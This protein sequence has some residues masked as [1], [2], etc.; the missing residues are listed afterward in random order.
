MSKT[1]KLDEDE[2]ELLQAIE[3]GAWKSVDKLDSEIS[4]FKKLATST[5][6]KNKRINIRISEQDLYLVQ[7]K[8]VHE[9]IPYQTLISSILHKY[10]KG[11]IT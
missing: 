11:E 5:L 3:K 9:G 6:K 7:R 4:K 10:V 8:A 1:I 2:A